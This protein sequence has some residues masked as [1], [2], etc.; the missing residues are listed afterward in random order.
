MDSAQGNNL[1]Q[2]EPPIGFEPIPDSFEANRSSVKLRGHVSEARRRFV[3]RATPEA[4]ARGPGAD[5]SSFRCLAW[6]AIG[7]RLAPVLF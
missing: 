7:E 6:E 5:P 3:I 4:S 2:M 1:G